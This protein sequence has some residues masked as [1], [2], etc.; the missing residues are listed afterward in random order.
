LDKSHKLDRQNSS[1]IS[2]AEL[3]AAL[4]RQKKLKE[5]AEEA[6]R[7]RQA[8]EEAR[9]E[10]EQRRA[11]EAERLRQ[12]EEEARLEAEQR[13]AEEAERLRQAEKEARLEAEQRKKRVES[14]VANIRTLLGLGLIA[15]GTLVAILLGS[16]YG[17]LMFI[18][19][20]ALFLGYG[21]GKNSVVFTVGSVFELLAF[22]C[23]GILIAIFVP[24]M[25]WSGIGF[26][27]D[28][29]GVILFTLPFAMAGFLLFR[30]YLLS[31]T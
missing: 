17:Y 18:P 27:Q 28:A 24:F 6:E 8:E 22:V 1:P 20:V 11:E 3:N 10:A 5:E 14:T 4:N 13:R 30:F 15:A 31:D 25:T 7:L 19:A 26:W 29:F 2:D 16:A 21:P 9:L 23:S 12:A